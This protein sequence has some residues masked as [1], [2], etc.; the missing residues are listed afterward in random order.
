MLL[1]ET[2]LLVE[3]QGVCEGK[4]EGSS[5]QEAHGSQALLCLPP[6]LLPPLPTARRR[7][8]VVGGS[9]SP[10]EKSLPHSGVPPSETKLPST[11]T[12]GSESWVCHLP[13]L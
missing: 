7:G 2:C 1:K 5:S 8:Q 11:D 4:E 9:V 6:V 12:L 13:A 10:T 3:S